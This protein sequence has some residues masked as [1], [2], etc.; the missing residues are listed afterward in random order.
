MCAFIPKCQ[1]LPF[2]VWCISASRARASF[3]VDGGAAMIVASTIVPSRSISPRSLRCA[4]ISRKIA[5]VS[6]FASSSRRN[7]NRVVA[8]GTASRARSIPVK[9]RS[10]WLS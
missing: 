6:R 3:F 8:S 5:S 2:L 7:F 9:P 10:A 1:A 4:L